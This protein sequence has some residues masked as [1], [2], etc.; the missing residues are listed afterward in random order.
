[1]SAATELNI[2][3]AKQHFKE[4]ESSLWAMIGSNVKYN[5][6]LL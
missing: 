1:M 6:G 3:N 5:L 4:L 2:Q